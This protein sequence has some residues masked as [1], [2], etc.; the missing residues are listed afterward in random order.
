MALDPRAQADLDSSLEPG[1]KVLWA[2]QH[3]WRVTMREAWRKIGL[4]AGVFALLG[5]F[6]GALLRSKNSAVVAIMTG[7]V[8][9]FAFLLASGLLLLASS[10]TRRRVYA[11]TDRGC[12]VIRRD[13]VRAVERYQPR[14]DEVTVAL[15]ADGTG[16]LVVAAREYPTRYGT[17]EQKLGF[18]NLRNPVAVQKIA[19]DAAASWASR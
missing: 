11:V 9:G 8:L 1:E 5:L 12:L 2:A 4:I 13:P 6:I 15:R 19:R 18:F 10:W 3:D 17:S 14:A 7:G 16:D